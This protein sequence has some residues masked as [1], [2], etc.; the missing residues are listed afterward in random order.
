[1]IDIT[2]YPELVKEAVKLID[3]NTIYNISPRPI[4]KCVFDA[5]G[6][7]KYVAWGF[8]HDEDMESVKKHL[9]E[10]IDHHFRLDML[11]PYVDGLIADGITVTDDIIN[12]FIKT[13]KPYKMIG[14]PTEELISNDDQYADFLNDPIKFSMMCF[15]QDSN[16]NHI[17][18]TDLVEP[19]IK[20]KLIE[21][22]INIGETE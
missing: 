2:Q 6:K 17:N 11:N 5:H 15:L 3:R 22:A 20:Q 1:M 12:E 8:P 19:Y 16:H 21:Q 9:V 14:E 10:V 13:T 4:I 18:L 7:E